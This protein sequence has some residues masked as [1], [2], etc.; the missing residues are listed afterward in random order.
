MDEL[1]GVCGAYWRCEHAPRRPDELQ[2]LPP[3]GQQPVGSSTDLGEPAGSPVVRSLLI[4]TVNGREAGWVQHMLGAPVP[5]QH[6]A[7]VP[8]PLDTDDALNL[9]GASPPT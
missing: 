4:E 6:V 9:W 1:C 8:A 7:R 5:R 2:E 3:P